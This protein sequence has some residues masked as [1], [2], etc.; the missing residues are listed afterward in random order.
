MKNALEVNFQPSNY[1]EGNTFIQRFASAYMFIEAAT[2]PE[3]M[4]YDPDV[5]G[6]CFGCGSGGEKHSC[7]K[8]KTAAKRCGFFFLFNTMCGN[9]S[10]RRRFDGTLTEM[11]ELIDE[12]HGC[13]S[14]F[15]VDFLFGYTGYSY[16]KCTDTSAFKNEIIASINAGK[17]V[18]AQTK[19]NGFQF[20]TGYDDDALIIPPFVGYDFSTNPPAERWEKTPEYKELSV[21]YIFGDKTTRR[22]TLKEGLNNIR[23]VMECNINEGLWDE[24]LKKL[25]GWGKFPSDDG[26]DQ[27]SADEKKARA[28]HLAKTNVYMYNFCSFGGAFCCEK[29]PDHYLHKEL[30]RPDLAELWNKIDGSHWAIVDAGHKTGMLNREQIW[31]IEDPAKLSA[32]SIEV[33]QAITMAQEADRKMLELI[34]Q[35]IELTDRA[36]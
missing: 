4:Y 22:Y 31:L 25:G 18:I 33:C 13:A 2:N 28:Q 30:F 26:L 11:Q 14:E 9:S 36:L 19:S 29:L 35:A 21:L 15:T 7:K 8:D 16:R 5:G 10:V 27:A 1:L 12:S 24:Y 34:K 6:Q 32:I 3:E 23:R 20:I 17:P